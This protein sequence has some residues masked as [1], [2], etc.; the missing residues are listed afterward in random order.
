M[1][2]NEIFEFSRQNIIGLLCSLCSL[3]KAMSLDFHPLCKPS[4]PPNRS[5]RRRQIFSLLEGHFGF[6][7][8][9]S[10]KSSMTYRERDRPLNAKK[11]EGRISSPPKIIIECK[12][13]C[14]G[15]SSL[16]LHFCLGGQNGGHAWRMLGRCDK[17]DYFSSY[18]KVATVGKNPDKN[19][20]FYFVPNLIFL[21]WFYWK[22]F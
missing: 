22:N 8:F 15:E 3:L 16:P 17:T 2:W 10:N 20:I 13:I 19:H 21:R 14:V 9:R 18:A 11:P 1:I 5:I 7:N 4:W 6:P 12:N